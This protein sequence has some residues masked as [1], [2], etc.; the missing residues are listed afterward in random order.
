MD[1][2]H[3]PDKKRTLALAFG[4]LGVVYGDIGT[5]PLYALREVFFGHHP[6][7]ASEPHVLGALSLFFWSLTIVVSIKYLAFM[8]RADNRGE[9]G[10]FALIGIIKRSVVFR[11]S[12]KVMTAAL[13]FGACLMYADGLIT[14]AISVLSAVEGVEVITP[15]LTKAVIPI[16]ICILI[17]LFLIQRQGTEKIGR[18]FGP[19]M[20][21]WFTVLILLAIPHLIK[22]PYVFI[23]LNPLY[24]ARFLFEQGVESSM[25]ILGSVVLCVTGGEALYADMGHFGRRPIRMAWFA[26]V[27]PAL[28]INYFGQGAF[29]LE[30][31]VGDGANLFYLLAPK[32]ALIPVVIM[33]TSATIIASQALI[34][35]AF[36]VT[37]Q[38]VGLGF[39]PK[40]KIV[41]TSASVRGQIYMP[42]INWML[43]FGCVS[44]VLIFKTSSALAAIYGITVTATMGLS[45]IALF[46]VATRIWGWKSIGIGIVC[47]IFLTVDVSFF[48]SNALKF[49]EGGFVPVVIAW[50][51]FS[52]MQLWSWGKQ[53]LSLIYSPEGLT[54]SELL[55]LKDV[56]WRG[57]FPRQVCFFAA[58][59]V[60]SLE[61][62][63]PLTLQTFMQRIHVLPSEI[64]F[65][66][67]KIHNEPFVDGE[68][69]ERY[70]LQDNMFS[71][72]I[73]YGYMEDPKILDILEEQNV[74]G[75]IV[76]GDHE[77]F[78]D[79]DEGF[80]NLRVRLFRNLM[81][82]S[83]PSY[84]YF[85][86]RGQSKIMKEVIPVEFSSDK[87]ALL[88]VDY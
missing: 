35:G 53:K 8:L 2:N 58:S 34:S 54:V 62:M 67:I 37:Q 65:V 39:L 32:W 64:V 87:A 44:L 86:L 48:V 20:L 55:S 10:E 57:Y 78:S 77:I 18:F 42:A 33:A 69:V 27:Y 85:G 3:S 15:A 82:L 17:G 23:A 80:H 16:T 56:E 76:V 45:S 75:N 40:I 12:A 26:L 28:L 50:G 83:L 66:T 63:I 9:G 61:S 74:K 72:V 24:G 59:P 31:Q 6:M 1:S 22:H 36:S 21:L 88:S 84:R 41:H 49:F 43:C 38:A 11:T 51:L 81:R 70:Q 7:A 13:V 47:L 5:S 73:N 19:I 4:A 46:Y 52:I 29:M 30:H 14:P 71:I 60:T 79:C 25:I 68:R